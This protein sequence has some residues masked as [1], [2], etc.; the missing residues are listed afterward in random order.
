MELTST[1]LDIELMK[2]MAIWIS[3]STHKILPYMMYKQ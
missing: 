1:L 3:F 2:K